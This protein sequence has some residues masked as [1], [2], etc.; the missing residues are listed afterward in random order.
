MVKWT[1]DIRPIASHHQQM[2]LFEQAGVRWITLSDTET[3]MI[4]YN[5]STTCDCA[6]GNTF[7]RSCI[8]DDRVKSLLCVGPGS[9]R[10]SI[11]SSGAISFTRTHDDLTMRISHMTDAPRETYRM[12]S[13]PV[14]SFPLLLDHWKRF[15]NVLRDGSTRVDV[16]DKSVTF[17]G[18][19]CGATFPA[20]ATSN[21]VFTIATDDFIF[22]LDHWDGS[23]A[24]MAVLENGVVRITGQ[25]ACAFLTPVL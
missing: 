2:L 17:S 18:D 16:T 22:A 3:A 24:T 21:A 9:V 13:T 23:D 1:L 11:R 20:Q 4:T 15:A 12:D 10:V 6:L 14:C 25:R 7:A 5:V 19:R 8:L